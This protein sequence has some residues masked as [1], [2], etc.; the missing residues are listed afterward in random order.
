M[1]VVEVVI[2]AQ[3]DTVVG[4]V[5]VGEGRGITV[6]RRGVIVLRGS[7]GGLLIKGREG[8]GVVEREGWLGRRGEGPIHFMWG[9]KL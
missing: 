5:E 2:W 7:G 1:V 3:V 6:G 8:G 9:S 4:R